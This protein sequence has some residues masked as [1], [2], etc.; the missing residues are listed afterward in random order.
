MWLIWRLLGLINIEKKEIQARQV[1]ER[2]G[3]H[4]HNGLKRAVSVINIESPLVIGLGKRAYGNRGWWWID[5]CFWCCKVVFQ[6]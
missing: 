6:P 1:V 4:M 5:K 2:N 3:F